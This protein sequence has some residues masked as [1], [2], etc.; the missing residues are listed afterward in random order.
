MPEFHPAAAPDNDRSGM[1][2][3]IGFHIDTHSPG[4]G[5]KI[6]GQGRIEHGKGRILLGNPDSRISCLLGLRNLRMQEFAAK[7]RE[8][9]QRII[10]IAHGFGRNGFRETVF[11]SGWSNC[12]SSKAMGDTAP[13][14]IRSP[15]IHP[16]K[17]SS[18]SIL[19]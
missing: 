14:R 2:G 18:F 10:G 1:N 11:P 9:L 13:L 5:D 12:I 7:K 15:A 8:Q 6:T 17:Y 19:P 16:V 4:L 3:V